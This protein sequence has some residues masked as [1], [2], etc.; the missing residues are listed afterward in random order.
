MPES[1]VLKLQADG[2]RKCS[3]C[4]VAHCSMLR[5]SLGSARYGDL[6]DDSY[7]L[8]CQ[9]CLTVLSKAIESWKFGR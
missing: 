9:T 8:L 6:K 1:E 3:L 2:Y 7:L 5:M 4:G